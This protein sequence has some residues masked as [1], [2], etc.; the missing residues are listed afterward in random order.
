MST[1]QI[2]DAAVA[3]EVRDKLHRNVEMAFY[4]NGVVSDDKTFKVK[5]LLVSTD[6]T[7]FIPKV[8]S[9]VVKEAIEPRLVISELFQTIRLN[10][11]RSIEFPAVGAMTAEDIP[12]A[13][14]YPE[15]QLDLGGGN[16]VA[17]NVTKS[18][19][20]VRIT[21]EMINDS[22]WDVIGMHLRAA[23]R[24]LA[25]HKEVKCATLFATMGQ[26]IFDNV[27]PDK[28]VVGATRGVDRTGALNGGIHLDDLFDMIAYLFQGA[29]TP[30]TIIMSPFAW[31]M[32]AKDPFLREIAW[33]GGRSSGVVSSPVR[34][35]RLAGTI[36][37]TSSRR[38]WLLKC[39]R[40][41][42][43]SRTVCSL[44]LFA[45]SSPRTSVSSE[46]CNRNQDV[47]WFRCYLYVGD[48][49]ERKAK[50]PLTDIYVI[51][52][53]ETGVIVQKQDVSTEDFNDPLRDIRSIKIREIYGL[54]TLSQG[55][56]IAVARNIAL[57][58][59]YNFTDVHQV[60]SVAS[61]DRNI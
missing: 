37:R 19:L 25:R 54:G 51:D 13:A 15:K 33:M 40:C 9:Q 6:F 4:N 21:E 56:S 12:E 7:M 52:D 58:Q 34:W 50:C 48:R 14:A 36:A 60:S 39:P 22:Q 35:E 45:S 44:F 46:G 10:V 26:K 17:I 3:K 53:A 38:L 24:A 11:G 32:F 57:A 61:P 42:S 23:G 1:Q 28:A 47:R 8:I 20:L 49:R 27:E 30:N 16:I 29:W 2:N 59:T 31:A 41:R 18:G 55:K 5:D 43:R